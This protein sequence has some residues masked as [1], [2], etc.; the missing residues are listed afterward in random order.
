M[1]DWNHKFTLHVFVDTSTKKWKS[2]KI[3]LVLCSNL[4]STFLFEFRVSDVP[5]RSST[6]MQLKY[7]LTIFNKISQLF[8]ATNTKATPQC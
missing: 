8:G 7:T 6:L 3:A 4:Y 2:K 5:A 1:N